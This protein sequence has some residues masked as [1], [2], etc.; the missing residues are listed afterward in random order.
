MQVCNYT[1]V[2]DLI[3]EWECDKQLKSIDHNNEEIQQLAEIIRKSKEASLLHCPKFIKKSE[4]EIIFD[5]LAECND[6][7]TFM[8]RVV[9]LKKYNFTSSKP[10]LQKYFKVVLFVS[11]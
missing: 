5:A 2:D 8:N 1:T 9:R 4:E 7:S 3:H 10:Y 6:T 11:S